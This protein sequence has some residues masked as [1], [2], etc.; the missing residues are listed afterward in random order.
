METVF[1]DIFVDIEHHVYDIAKPRIKIELYNNIYLYFYE[2][3]TTFRIVDL[4]YDE[5]YSL[6]LT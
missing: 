4:V 3:N 1:T 6:G 2:T 5:L